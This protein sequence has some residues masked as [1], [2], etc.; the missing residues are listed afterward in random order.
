MNL[1]LARQASNRSTPPKALAGFFFCAKP[2]GSGPWKQCHG[3]IAEGAKTRSLL[4]QVQ[5]CGLGKLWTHFVS[6]AAATCGL[7]LLLAKYS[8][9]SPTSTRPSLNSI[10][11]GCVALLSSSAGQFLP[12]PPVPVA[13]VAAPPAPRGRASRAFRRA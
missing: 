5:V 9:R 7:R 10:V 12:H 2:D 1:L 3:P 13:R 6:C 11:F 4:Y 8:G